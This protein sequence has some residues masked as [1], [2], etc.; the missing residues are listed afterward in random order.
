MLERASQIIKKLQ[1]LVDDNAKPEVLLTIS[2]MLV[3]EL[4][5]VQAASPA[6]SVSITMP[7]RTL[8]IAEA[9]PQKE[10][11]ETIA[12]VVLADTLV[13]DN[14]YNS[15]KEE[16]IPDYSSNMETTYEPTEE[17]ITPIEARE[18]YILEMPEAEEEKA[19]EIEEPKHYEH[20]LAVTPNDILYESTTQIPTLPLFEQPVTHINEAFGK[21]ESDLNEKYKES[22][23][24][25][26]H[27]LDNTH[28]KD[29][30]RA[31][32]INEKYLF[33]NE[34]FGG[35]EAMYDRSIKHIQSFSILPEA[36]FWIQ[37]E[38]KIKYKW[39]DSSEVVQ[40]FDQL[41]KR[42]FS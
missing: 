19:T 20:P 28:I 4:Q 40:L 22:K 31:I 7:R 11:E 39:S 15:N 37:R 17:V 30:K 21:S 14:E 25:V 24:E 26:A 34:L 5:Q 38:L 8:V 13:E 32:T 3:A 36:T 27:L 29:L 41:V 33:I 23:V 18:E 1:E 6:S 2:E 12:P 10:A 16:M 42:R 9:L 35:D